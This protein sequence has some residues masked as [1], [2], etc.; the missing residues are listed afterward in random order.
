MSAPRSMK[1]RACASAQFVSLVSLLLVSFAAGSARADEVV[2]PNAAANVEGNSSNCIP[3][4][5]C[6][7]VARYQQVHAN[8]QFAAIGGPVFVTELA[9]RPDGPAAP[10]SSHTFSDVEVILSTTTNGPDALSTTFA[11]NLGP[12]ATV[13]YR[14]ALT[15][16]ATPDTNSPRDFSIRISL[17]TPF[18]FDPTLGRHLLFQFRNLGGECSVVQFADAHAQVEPGAPV[19][20]VFHFTSGDGPCVAGDPNAPVAN[21]SPGGL[22]LVTE[23]TYV[24]ELEAPPDPTLTTLRG[25]P[26]GEGER[27]FINQDSVIMAA[28]NIV[29]PG[30]FDLDVC[31]GK[32]PRWVKKKIGTKFF[33]VFIPRILLPREL[34]GSGSCQGPLE[35]GSTGLP[36]F[37]N[38]L[39]LLS[40]VE[41][42]IL[43]RYMS[44]KGKFC[45]SEA[46][47][48]CVPEE[49]YWLQITAFR[50][51]AQFAGVNGLETPPLIDY[52]DT[53]A[54]QRPG[55]NVDINFRERMLG[56]PVP[57]FG[58]YEDQKGFLLDET[59][60][61]NQV[62]GMI[63]R[64]F[65]AGPVRYV[66]NVLTEIASIVTQLDTTRLNIDD[67]AACIS[68]GDEQN[69]RFWL[70]RGSEALL[71]H[72][73]QTAINAF[74]DGAR[75]AQAADFAACP[76]EANFEGGLVANFVQVAFTTHDRL[77]HRDVY[78]RFEVPADLNLPL[79]VTDE[80]P[81]P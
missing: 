60:Q 66:S 51:T 57:A 30:I 28:T 1:S 65:H 54:N 16:V 80:V 47:P 64:S 34:A 42:V 44:Y 25:E 40:A 71:R 79:L 12:D 50:T 10:F 35:P 4:T 20:R 41:D 27:T 81:I 48:S 46:V 58:D 7:G 74:L 31:V 53:P 32:D 45:D 76:V 11:E 9:F 63:R 2:V 17:Q 18:P 67:A 52:S 43:P 37:A 8:S 29:V 72:D 77:L 15:L 6:L 75:A 61:C 78:D 55:C 56:S 49:G 33:D 39:A 22:G 69:L 21:L 38:W 24:D 36:Q 14:G 73:Y 19:S 59:A 68:D 23:F 13:V 3:L 5:G 70:R 62:K 26:T